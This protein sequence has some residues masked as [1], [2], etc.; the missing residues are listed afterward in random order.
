[1]K[2]LFKDP[3]FLVSILLAITGGVQAN[4]G[5]LSAL[6]TEYPTA[7]GLVMSTISIVTAVLTA[8]KTMLLNQ[9]KDPPK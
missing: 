3:L 9:P 7:F 5:Q 8:V 2:N 4:T 1:M 6:A